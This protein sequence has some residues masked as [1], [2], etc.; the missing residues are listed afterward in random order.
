MDRHYDNA[1]IWW[2]CTTV[3][4]DHIT[5]TFDS[6]SNCCTVLTS[7]L[8][9]KHAC[10]SIIPKC[11]P[12]HCD[13]VPTTC[14]IIQTVR[15]CHVSRIKKSSERNSKFDLTNKKVWD[16]SDLCRICRQSVVNGQVASVSTSALLPRRDICPQVTDLCQIRQLQ[17]RGFS[18]GRSEILWW[19]KRALSKPW[20]HRWC[21]DVVTV[22]CVERAVRRHR[23]GTAECSH[24]L[25]CCEY[26][27]HRVLRLLCP[28]SIKHKACIRRDIPWPM[29]TQKGHTAPLIWFSL[30][31]VGPSR[32]VPRDC[33]LFG[34]LFKFSIDFSFHHWTLRTGE[35]KTCTLPIFGVRACACVRAYNEK[36]FRA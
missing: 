32:K 28:P 24:C 27:T 31:F 9:G 33:R 12:G 5:A 13:P 16:S 2:Q 3:S 21:V 15:T 20:R 1:F 36:S 25:S 29:T 4:C 14:R 19:A 35:T 23:K 34:H 26:Q 17:K 18:L 11:S 22:K 30:I 10:S 6:A 7:D 8:F